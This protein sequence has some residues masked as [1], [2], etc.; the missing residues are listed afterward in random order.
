M[1][2]RHRGDGVAGERKVAAAAAAAAA[3]ASN[4]VPSEG[5]ERWQSFRAETYDDERNRRERERERERER[6]ARRTRESRASC[7]RRKVKDRD[8]ERE[9]VQ[10]HRNNAASEQRGGQVSK[11]PRRKKREDDPRGKGGVAEYD[12]AEATRGKSAERKRRRGTRRR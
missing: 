6:K 11:V 9:E 12:Y 1:M 5:K 2:R 7:A 4:K 8:G 3:V 10:L